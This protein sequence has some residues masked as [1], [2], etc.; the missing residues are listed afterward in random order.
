MD[1]GVIRL[2][3]IRANTP[4]KGEEMGMLPLSFPLPLCNCVVVLNEC[5]PIKGDRLGLPGRL[6]ID[7]CERIGGGGSFRIRSHRPV[8]GFC[9]QSW[10]QCRVLVGGLGTF[11][12]LINEKGG[13]AWAHKV[14]GKGRKRVFRQRIYMSNEATGAWCKESATVE[15]ISSIFGKRVW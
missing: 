10:R 14:N 15:R 1:R 13:A 6:L 4:D 3:A 5:P 12:H 8:R 7:N 2:I 9:Y 11:V